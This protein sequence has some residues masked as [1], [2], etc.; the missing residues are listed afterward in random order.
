MRVSRWDTEENQ[1]GGTAS[2]DEAPRS[3]LPPE[4]GSATGETGA[5]S[6][7][8]FMREPTVASP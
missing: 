8:E 1:N 5:E 3:T 6:S 2:D 4:N 7:P